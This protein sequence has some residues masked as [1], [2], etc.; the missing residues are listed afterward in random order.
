MDNH[1]LVIPARAGTHLPISRPGNG[2]RWILEPRHVTR[3]DF[4]GMTIKGI[5]AEE[6]RAA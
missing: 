3:F 6:A 4:A 5:A 1:N 2:V